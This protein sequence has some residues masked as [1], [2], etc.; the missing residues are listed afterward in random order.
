MIV[1]NI[2]RILAAITQINGYN[3]NIQL[4]THSIKSNENHIKF[5][6]IRMFGPYTYLKYNLDQNLIFYRPVVR[7]I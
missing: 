3:Y 1:F 2:R 7:K 6:S 5:R 4:F